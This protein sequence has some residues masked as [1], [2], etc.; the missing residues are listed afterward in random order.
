MY[1][2]GNMKLAHKLLHR[3]I[4]AWS[5]ECRIKNM[6][7]KRDKCQFDNVT[8]EELLLE[9]VIFNIYLMKLQTDEISHIDRLAVIDTVLRI[10]EASE[11]VQICHPD[12]YLT[13]AIALQR[14][15]NALALHTPS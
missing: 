1:F 13:L 9:I 6:R 5:N 12:A 15:A 7:F 2:V 8:V 10:I 14:T 4:G 11:T 3:A